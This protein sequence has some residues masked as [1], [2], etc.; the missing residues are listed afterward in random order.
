[1]R[2]LKRAAFLDRDGTINVEKGYLYKK[3]D[4][5]Y[6]EG[7]IEGLR[8]LQDSGYTLVIVTNQSG[9]ARGY[10]SE[11]DFHRLMDWM[12]LDLKEKEIHIEKVYYCPHHPK[13]KIEKYTKDCNC[14]KP[15]TEL[16]YRAAKE[17]EIDLNQSIAIGDKQRDL[18]ICNETGMRGILI[19]ENNKESEKII[20][21]RDWKEIACFI[22]RILE[23]DNA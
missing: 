19:S 12:I 11:E 3:E 14:R 5:E 1:M 23:Y 8:M 20:S 22:E 18:E 4:F 13:G 21:C 15:K 17:L 7:A 9:I 6:L 16:F 10:Y 2:K